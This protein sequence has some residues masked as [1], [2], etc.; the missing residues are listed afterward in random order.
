MENK[1]YTGLSDVL[2][3]TIKNEG[4]IGLYK[5]FTP[6]WMRFGPFTTVQLMVWE[7]LRNLYGMK[8][9]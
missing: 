6:Q 4:L 2:A 5:G 9:I 1:L 3:K 7:F 8:G